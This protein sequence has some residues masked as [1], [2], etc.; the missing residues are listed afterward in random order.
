MEPKGYQA[1]FGPSPEG[2]VGGELLGF[3]DLG[4]RRKPRKWTYIRRVEK[5]EKNRARRQAIK[6][7]RRRA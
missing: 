6:A 7:A 5:R 3:L 2:T 1:V 4:A